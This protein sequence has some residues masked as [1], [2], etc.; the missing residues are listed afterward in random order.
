MDKFVSIKPL[1]SQLA[2]GKTVIKA[3]DYKHLIS[4]EE[5]LRT[6]AQR[7]RER[8]ARVTEAMTKAIQKGMEQGRE[9]AH[10]QLVDQLLGHTIRMNESL[11]D[12]ELVLVDVVVEAV[13]QIVREFDN[14]VLVT[15]TVRR[16]MELVRGGKKLIVRVHPQMHEVVSE[17]LQEWQKTVTH[18]EVMA[19]AQL[20]LDECVLESD[21]GIVNAGVELQLES[22]IRSLRRAFPVPRPR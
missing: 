6:L 1:D 3:Q 13:Q 8:E 19:D 14:K 17:Q 7:E 20:K 15:N 21:V 18:V 2:P 22:L 5:L 4:Y 10:H 12:V 11:R 9:Q 16:A